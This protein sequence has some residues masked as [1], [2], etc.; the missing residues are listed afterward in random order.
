LRGGDGNDS[1]DGKQGNDTASL[2]AGDDTFRWDAGD[3]SDTVEGDDGQDA[4]VFNGANLAE[5]VELSANGSRARLFRDIG[6][7]TMD[8]NGVERVE[9]D[10]LGGADTVTVND[11]T[12]TDVTEADVDL[13]AAPGGPADGAPDSVIVNATNGADDVTLAG[14]QRK[15]FAVAGLHAEVLV[16]G[17]DGPIDTLTLHAR[18]GDDDVDASA[19]QAGAMSLTLDGGD[20][21]DRLTGS[22]GDDVLIGGNGNDQLDGGAGND[23]LTQ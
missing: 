4:L 20:G 17:T 16:R 15:G 9:T 2:G 18:G 11:L 13:T 21:D 6:R 22:G 5:N 1:V 8:L 7:V 14:T 23:V 19:L 12:G 10:A 3:G